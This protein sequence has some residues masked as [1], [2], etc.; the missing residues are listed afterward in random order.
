MTR[1]E[2]I[3]RAVAARLDEYEVERRITLRNV[4]V[5]IQL[6]PG[7]AGLR[8]VTLILKDEQDLGVQ[9]SLDAGGRVSGRP[10]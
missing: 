6:R 4:I 1:T 9:E 10:V 3:L 5:D 2:A 7:R 8:A